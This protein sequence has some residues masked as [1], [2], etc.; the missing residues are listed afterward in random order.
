MSSPTRT[1][2]VRSHAMATA[3]FLVI[4]LALTGCEPYFEYI[5]KEEAGGKGG[6]APDATPISASGEPGTFS[7]TLQHDGRSRD[8]IV[9]VPASYDPSASTALMLNFHGYGGTASDYMMWA[10]MRDLAEQDGVIVVYPQGSLLEGSPHWNAALPGGDN[11]SSVDDLGF[12]R[13]LVARVGETHAFDAE[14]VY[15]TGYSNGGMMAVAL[16]CYASDV[17]AAVS[18][19]S[20]MQ[21]DTSRAC[22]PTHPTGFISLHGTADSVLSYDGYGGEGSAQDA[23]DFWVDVNDIGGSPAT[24]Q[25]RDGGMTIER[26]VYSGGRNGVS[27]EHYRYVGGGHVWFE[28]AF[29]GADASELVWDFLMQHDIRGAR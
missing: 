20:G 25:A 13:A 5:G 23:V 16:G 15:A 29:D 2:P 4:G 8:A 19:V 24:E 7:L 6:S 28:E 27:V 10:D 11:K 18:M 12:V 14:R 21:L 3:L 26:T 9:Y 17:V 22:A 1:A